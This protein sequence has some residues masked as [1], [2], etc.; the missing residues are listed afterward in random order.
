MPG[1]SRRSKENAWF[2]TSVPGKEDG[3]RR[4]S[5]LAVVV[6]KDL[7]TADKVVNEIIARRSVDLEGAC[8]VFR[9]ALG[10]PQPSL[11]SVRTRRNVLLRLVPAVGHC[12]TKSA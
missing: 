7:N 10:R 2:G 4:V 9:D 3:K 12:Q 6:F 8:V 5:D 11:S 1:A